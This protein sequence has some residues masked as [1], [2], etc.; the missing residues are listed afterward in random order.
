MEIKLSLIDR[1]LLINL[2]KKFK[3]DKRLDKKKIRLYINL[4]NAGFDFVLIIII[5]FL[6]ITRKKYIK[7]KRLLRGEIDLQFV[8][9]KKLKSRRK[10]YKLKN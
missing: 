8:N 1:I 2:R 9:K 3:K 6:I 5:I 10:R 7:R 4:I